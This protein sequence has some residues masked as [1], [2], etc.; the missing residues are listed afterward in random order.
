MPPSPPESGPDFGTFEGGAGAAGGIIGTNQLQTAIDKF[1]QAVTTLDGIAEKL[2]NTGTGNGGQGAGGAFPSMSNPFAQPNGGWP[3]QGPPPQQPWGETNPNVLTPSNIF[4]PG[5]PYGSANA[6]GSVFTPTM[7]GEV[8]GEG[9]PGGG[10]GGGAG[11][12][13]GGWGGNGGGGAGGGSGGGSGGGNGGWGFPPGGGFTATSVAGS[14]AAGMGG[15]G[16][17]MVGSMANTALSYAPAPVAAAVTGL[18]SAGAA[19]QPSQIALN[20]L[21]YQSSIYGQ[22][23][24]TTRIGAMGTAGTI[25]GG[26]QQIEWGMNPQDMAATYASLQQTTAQ[27]NPYAGGPGS[28]GGN[29]VIAGM[30]AAN[31]ANPAMSGVQ[32]ASAMQQLY[33][34]QTSLNMMQ[35]GYGATPRQIGTGNAQPFATTMDPFLERLGG[36]KPLTQQQLFAQM[37][38]NQ[39]GYVGLQNLTGASPDQMNQYTNMLGIQNA[40]M[41]GQNK[42]KDMTTSQVNS[43][44]AQLNGSPNQFNAAKNTL[45]QYG[46]Q[47]SAIQS[48]KSQAGNQAESISD[49][50]QGFINGLKTSTRLLSDFATGLHKVINSI[51]GARG[52]LGFGESV[53]SNIFGGGAASPASRSGDSGAATSQLSKS[54]AAHATAPAKVERAVQLAKTQVGVQYAYGMEQPGEG[55]DCAA[56]PQWAYKAAGV[57]LPRTAVDQLRYLQGKLVNPQAAREGDLVFQPGAGNQAHEAMLVD[58]GRNIIEARGVGQP[59]SIRRY[60]PGEWPKAARPYK[61]G[62]APSKNTPADNQKTNVK[63]GGTGHGSG[64]Q[65]AAYAQT[66]A[67]GLNHPYVWGGASPTSG[68]DCSG[69]AADVYEH[70]GYVP[71][72]GRERWGN[73]TT[74]FADHKYLQASGPVVGALVYEAGADGTV[75]KPGHVGIMTGPGK[76]VAAADPAQGTIVQVPQG[77]SGYRIPKGGFNGTSG[78]ASSGASSGTTTTTSASGIGSSGGPGGM[79]AGLGDYA[80]EGSQTELS[81][82]AG[83]IVAG[84]LGGSG[85]MTSTSTSTTGTPAGA[86]AGSA[87][88]GTIALAKY[89]MRAGYSKA[90]AAAAAGVANGEGGGNPESYEGNGSATLAQAKA[91]KSNH[92]NTP[93]IGAGLIGWTPA[94][95]MTRHGGTYGT[96]VAADMANQEKA[97][98][99]WMKTYGWPPPQG[100]F[101]QTAAGA[102]KAAYSASAAYERPTVAGSDVKPPEIQSVFNALATG[103]TLESGGMAWVGERGPELISVSQDSTVHDAASSI[104]MASTAMA[105]SAQGPW[106]ASGTSGQGFSYSTAHPLYSGGKSGSGGGVQVTFASGAVIINGTGN[107]GSAGMTTT[108]NGGAAAAQMFAKQFQS[109]TAKMNLACAIGSGV[110]S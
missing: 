29:N 14:V 7:P 8:P 44:F 42:Q 99:S 50:S 3:Q 1:T 84:G 43:L 82:F 37:A 92:W 21:Q 19:S 46:V 32:N 89:L 86:P 110:S 77:V 24:N 108:G 35:M 23:Y 39:K 79:A 48:M 106:S 97:M 95:S 73:T 12:G 88:T 26:Q 72:N 10:A 100:G 80:G 96:T 85:T 59:I 17:G 87:S 109:E 16:S 56:L 22:N 101:P 83:A 28:F 5:Q 58:N 33:S 41:T 18:G 20:T 76:M 4:A 2:P 40:L 93:G 52:I 27:L 98:V 34:P 107:T 57:T 31:I 47:Q 102:V 9:G 94:S 54:M 69:F 105:Q 30:N 55:F 60:V 61:P 53:I 51:P 65:I 90:A 103:G 62:G 74:Q 81:A 49:T 78:G 91:W 70:F 64:A 6:G 13:G 38:P 71:G 45:Q 25:M 63:G 75:A 67:T 68:W 66:F 36:G 11:G 104:R 15:G